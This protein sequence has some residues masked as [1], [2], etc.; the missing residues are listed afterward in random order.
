[1][2]R[3]PSHNRRPDGATRMNREDEA[4]PRLYFSFPFILLDTSRAHPKHALQLEA[5]QFVAR[6]RGNAIARVAA[7]AEGL[8]TPARCALLDAPDAS[9]TGASAGGATL[10]IKA[11]DARS[12]AAAAVLVRAGASPLAGGA[13]QCAA[14]VLL[15]RADGGRAT[16][17]DTLDG[18]LFAFLALATEASVGRDGVVRLVGSQPLAVAFPPAAAGAAA[19]ARLLLRAAR[20]YA[21]AP[22]AEFG[23]RMAAVDLQRAAACDWALAREA[24]EF[25][26]HGGAGRARRARRARGCASCAALAPARVAVALAAAL[27]ITAAVALCAPS[28]LALALLATAAVFV[29]CGCLVLTALL[30]CCLNGTTRCDMDMEASDVRMII[31]GAAAQPWRLCAEALGWE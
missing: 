14:L 7:A 4:P 2:V 21:R 5:A 27:F 8:L 6:G 24:A 23:E 30:D 25:A 19:R 3:V 11:V 17:G 10:L 22:P 20:V 28:S 1:M 9:L 15:R 18:G 29:V 31:C 16:H 26:A 12:L 13:L